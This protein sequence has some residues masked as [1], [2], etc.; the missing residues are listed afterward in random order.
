MQKYLAKFDFEP[1]DHLAIGKKYDL[2]DFDNG[3]KLATSKFVYLKNEAAIL[4]LALINWAVDF[5][6]KK[7]YTFMITPDLC[8]SSIIDGCGFIPR[9]TNACKE[10]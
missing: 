3:A 9:N 7:G 1:L 6:R 5:L 2:L 10:I 8:K 4:E